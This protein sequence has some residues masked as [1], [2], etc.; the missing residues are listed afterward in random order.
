MGK[1][2]IANQMRARARQV[3]H[4]GSYGGLFEIAVWCHMRKVNVL[5]AFG[6]TILNVYAFFGASLPQFTPTKNTNLLQ[7]KF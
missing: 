7:R 1:K 4:D 2:N 3:R 6:V 5:L